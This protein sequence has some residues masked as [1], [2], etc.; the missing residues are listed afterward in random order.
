MPLGI[1]VDLGPGQIV[2]D[3][4]PASLTER[5]TGAPP[6]FS[7]HFALAQSPISA[8]AELMYKQS[9]KNQFRLRW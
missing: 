7:A 4:D 9:P 5:H 8:T 2:F 6:H 1:K 3:G